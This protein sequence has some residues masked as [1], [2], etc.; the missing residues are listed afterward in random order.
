MVFVV[1]WV[2]NFSTRFSLHKVFPGHDKYMKKKRKYMSHCL[3]NWEWFFYFTKTEQISD[4]KNG[5]RVILKSLSI[6]LRWLLLAITNPPLLGLGQTPTFPFL[7]TL[8]S[9]R[10]PS[11]ISEGFS[12][13]W[14]VP[15]LCHWSQT[16]SSYYSPTRNS[17]ASKS[18]R[19]E[20]KKE[21]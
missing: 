10:L 5:D 15:V 13:W 1:L 3:L 9:R 7:I 2:Q 8:C 6:V 11:G 12:I 14:G 4:S 21:T 17:S 20:R 19:Y 18:R 16:S